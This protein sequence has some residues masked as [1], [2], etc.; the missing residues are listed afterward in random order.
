MRHAIAGA[1]QGSNCSNLRCKAELGRHPGMSEFGRLGHGPMSDLS[2]LSGEER[3]LDFGAVRSV[4]DPT[5]TLPFRDPGHAQALG[6]A[7][8]LGEVGWV[9][10]L[11]VEAVSTN[12]EGRIER[13]SSF[14]GGPRLFTRAEQR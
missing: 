5:R 6:N 1:W 12:R 10:A 2:P 9:I 8:A 13:K 14:G 11:W 4:D 7:L 3:K